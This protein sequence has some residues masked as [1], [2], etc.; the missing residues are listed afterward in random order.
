MEVAT[1]SVPAVSSVSR[2]K[3]VKAVSPK[4]EAAVPVTVEHEEPV[5]VEEE[6]IESN[7]SD[8]LLMLL[9]M[10]LLFVLLMLGLLFL[11]LLGRKYRII[12]I[13]KNK[14]G[15]VDEREVKRFASFKKA[16]KYVDQYDWHRDDVELRIF[17]A[18]RDKEVRYCGKKINKG[19]VYYTNMDRS[20]E[21]SDYCN[22]KE[23]SVMEEVLGFTAQCE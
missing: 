18:G 11:A 15:D 8:M 16:C 7:D 9:L 19:N 1:T 14:D 23:A 10:L 17:N 20:L 12:R 5:Q 6:V 4:K 13:V 21:G 2:K 3:A 22:E